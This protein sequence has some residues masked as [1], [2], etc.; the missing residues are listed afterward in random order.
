MEKQ[1]NIKYNLMITI[2]YGTHTHTY[3]FVQMCYEVKK[4]IKNICG[5]LG[6]LADSLATRAKVLMPYCDNFGLYL[7]N[8]RN[9][10]DEW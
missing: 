2:D 9:F 3:I 1:T 6:R 10:T 7:L 5:F 4:K 8:M